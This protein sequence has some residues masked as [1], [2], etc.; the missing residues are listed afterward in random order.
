FAGKGTGQANYWLHNEFVTVEGEKMS[1]SEGN[2]YTVRELL[3]QHGGNAIRLYL[4]SS[5]YRSEMDFSMEGLERAEKEL[6]KVRKTVQRIEKIEGGEKASLEVEA[7]ENE[8][9]EYMDDDLNTAKAEQALMDFVGEVNSALEEGKEV[10]GDV[11][12]KIVELFGVLGVDVEPEISEEEEAVA[13]LL[14]QLRERYRQEDD[15]ETADMI[16]ETLEDS[17]FAVEDTGEGAIW[18][19]E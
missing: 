10:D 3:E 16:R 11:G 7:L 9:E 12:E 8:F 2:F 19:K 18:L 13:D 15:Y 6:Q 14:L 4:I 1:K 17:G 5:H